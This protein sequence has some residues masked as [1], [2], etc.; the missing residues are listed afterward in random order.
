M[1]R[2][3]KL[4][5]TPFIN[6]RVSN[7]YSDTNFRMKFTALN[8]DAAPK[9]QRPVNLSVART[10]LLIRCFIQKMLLRKPLWSHTDSHYGLRTIEFFLLENWEVETF[11]KTFLWLNS[12]EI[13]YI[14]KKNCL[15]LWKHCKNSAKITRQ[16]IT[17]FHILSKTRI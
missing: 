3:R 7:S 12:Q 17:P 13:Y 5:K 6:S 14:E 4:M 15:N 11:M 10:A 1:K 8:F 9:M 2:S 16:Q